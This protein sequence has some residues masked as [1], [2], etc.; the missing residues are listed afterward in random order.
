MFT[1]IHSRFESDD[2]HKYNFIPNEEGK[3]E[4]TN[5]KN[6][7]IVLPLWGLD[8]LDLS[9]S[10]TDLGKY[11]KSICDHFRLN[12]GD[13]I[14]AEALNSIKKRDLFTWRY[15]PYESFFN[16]A[17][18]QAVALY[19]PYLV[20]H[21]IKEFKGDGWER[22]VD[23]L[24]IA[25]FIKGEYDFW[26]GK[27]LKK[28]LELKYP[29]LES[30]KISEYS[31]GWGNFDSHLIYLNIFDKKETKNRSV[32]IPLKAFIDRD[33]EAIKKYH[34]EYFTEYYSWP[35]GWGKGTTEKDVLGW[36]KDNLNL[37]ESDTFK[38]FCDYL[39]NKKEIEKTNKKQ[40]VVTLHVSGTYKVV[41]ECD[42]NCSL[43][44]LKVAAV[45][46][47]EDADDLGELEDADIEDFVRYS[48][49]EGEY[50]F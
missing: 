9:P 42:E 7:K 33:V 19:L 29:W 34:T 26:T 27:L 43:N 28:C 31:I 5:S 32:Y 47:F 36:R 41:V 2:K 40:F 18:S 44:D 21:P 38:E 16:Y 10:I 37:L 50:E 30:F 45:D 24:C 6:E 8:I 11:D 35:R 46:A 22:S 3:Y 12:F 1:Y 17:I 14:L 15:F 49:D 4:F 48:S 13:E 25:V 23:K 39:T 20:T